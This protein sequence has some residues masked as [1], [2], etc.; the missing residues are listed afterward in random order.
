MMFLVEKIVWNP[1]HL[2]GESVMGLARV[3][4]YSFVD[5]VSMAESLKLCKLILPHQ[6]NAVFH[7]IALGIKNF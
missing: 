3:W 5:C 2:P 7:D 1:T 4:T 6:D